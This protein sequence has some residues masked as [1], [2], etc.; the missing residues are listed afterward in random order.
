M[1]LRS[2]GAGPHQS[3]AGHRLL[4]IE[5][6]EQARRTFR[7]RP[8]LLYPFT[9]QLLSPMIAALAMSLSSVAVITNALRL[10]RT[11]R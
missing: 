2:S 5:L 9:G 10:R 11:T 3:L 6:R 7:W 4:V 8:T 1:P